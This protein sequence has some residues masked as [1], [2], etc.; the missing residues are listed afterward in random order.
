VLPSPPAGGDTYDDGSA[1]F[2]GVSLRNASNKPIPIQTVKSKILNLAGPDGGV[3]M[4]DL[5]TF[6]WETQVGGG[7]CGGWG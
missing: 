3:T 4:G 5:A 6:Q 1:K 2:M 7:R